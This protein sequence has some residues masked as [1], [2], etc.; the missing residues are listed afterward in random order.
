[1]RRV[2]PA[3]QGGTVVDYY[4]S[5]FGFESKLCT[6]VPKRVNPKR[7]MLVARRKKH[8]ESDIGAASPISDWF[9][10][11]RSGIPVGATQIN[12]NTFVAEVTAVQVLRALM[13]K[14]H[15]PKVHNSLLT[16]LH[17]LRADSADAPETHR[18]AVGLG[19][20]WP[21]AIAKEFS[22][23]EQNGSWRTIL[24]SEV[25]VGRRLH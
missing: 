4:A 10:Y 14:G 2:R 6:C 18:E 20:P 22:N 9:D 16:V 13:T 19:P 17:A 11:D 21:A 5:L 7:G 8:D 15:S 3:D 23:H 24:R 25:P 12:H 1:M